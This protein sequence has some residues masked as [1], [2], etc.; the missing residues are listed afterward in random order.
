VAAAV[1]TAA[2]SA[3]AP[4]TATATSVSIAAAST[5]RGRE[6]RFQGERVVAY[7]QLQAQEGGR[8]AQDER[9]RDGLASNRHRGFE[10]PRERARQR[11]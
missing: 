11:G 4:A 5:F 9:E 8:N 10:A 2:G 7:D 1:V 6:T 3:I